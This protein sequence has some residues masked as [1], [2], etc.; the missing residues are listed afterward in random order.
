MIFAMHKFLSEALCREIRAEYQEALD[1]GQIVPKG[2]GTGKT[3]VSLLTISAVDGPWLVD[4]TADWLRRVLH[5]PPIT[6]D[7]CA[8]TRLEVGQLHELHADAVKLD[9]TPNHT[10]HRVATAL[11]YLSDGYEEFDGGE[12]YLPEFGMTIVATPGLLVGMPTD[13][14]HRHAV[15]VVTRG[16][17]DA[18]ALWYKEL[19]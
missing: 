14:A 6:L 15:T 8:Y 18:I 7:Y 16:V 19:T 11:L 12:L 17:R 3:D 5:I 10:P 2:M 9:G 13:L 4:M 1:A